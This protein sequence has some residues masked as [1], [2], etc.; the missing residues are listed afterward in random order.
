MHNVFK[1]DKPVLSCREEEDVDPFLPRP[2][3]PPPPHPLPHSRDKNGWQRYC[4]GAPPPQ[5]AQHSPVQQ[6]YATPSNNLPSA[7]N[8]IHPEA[9][10][11]S[12]SGTKDPT[13]AADPSTHTTADM[14]DGAEARQETADSMTEAAANSQAE[15][16]PQ[17]TD[18]VPREASSAMVHEAQAPTGS[19]LAAAP[20]SASDAQA[21]SVMM[22]DNTEATEGMRDA[23]GSTSDAE[24]TPSVGH[25]PQM[26]VLASLDQVGSAITT[27]CQLHLLC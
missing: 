18:G 25:P 17:L 14:L 6:L 19:M 10:S 4:L 15:T 27:C 21:T 11:A 20:V 26:A 22:E 23:S 8:A 13:K 5:Q 12:S 2:P 3:P 7:L 16:T 1:D 9:A 24:A